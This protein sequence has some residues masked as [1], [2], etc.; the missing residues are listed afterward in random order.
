MS[1]NT[2]SRRYDIDWLRTLA[3]IL[4]IFYHI[5]QFYVADWA[6]T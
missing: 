6:G 5:G 2:D 1:I 3:F 4:L